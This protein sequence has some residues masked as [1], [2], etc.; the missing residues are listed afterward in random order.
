MHFSFWCEID[1]LVALYFRYNDQ[2]L[3]SQATISMMAVQS[4]QNLKLVFWLFCWVEYGSLFPHH[5]SNTHR[6]YFQF[7]NYPTLEVEYP[8]PLRRSGFLYILADL[9]IAAVLSWQ[10]EL[11]S[12]SEFG[13]QSDWFQVL[14]WIRSGVPEWPAQYRWVLL[15]FMT[16]RLRFY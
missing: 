2:Y 15:L 5:I 10:S 7:Q 11:P 14:V 8:F 4:V 13:I 1:W 9:W 16:E 3:E 6:Q 12:L